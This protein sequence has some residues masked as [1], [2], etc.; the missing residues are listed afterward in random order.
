MSKLA[1]SND[2]TMRQ[3][4]ADR[5]REEGETVCPHCNGNNADAPCAYPSEFPP[6]CLRNMPTVVN[7]RKEAYDQYIGRGSIWGN[8]F[9]IGVH[10]DRAEVIAL[11][12]KWIRAHPTLLK[13]LFRLRGKRLGCYCKPAACHGDVLVKLMKEMKT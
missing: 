3:I 1:H 13:Q 2:E 4:E 8:P 12:E 9:R 5:R 7:C 10:G 6:G 11:Y